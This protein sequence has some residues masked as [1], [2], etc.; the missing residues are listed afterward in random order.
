MVT[1]INHSLRA[2]TMLNRRTP[3]Q[4]D[5]P[6]IASSFSDDECVQKLA[7]LIEH[8]DNKNLDQ[9]VALIR[10]VSGCDRVKIKK[11]PPG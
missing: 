10:P 11:N 5:A 8:R 9:I 3:L 7:L 4:R 1:R 2:A 6:P